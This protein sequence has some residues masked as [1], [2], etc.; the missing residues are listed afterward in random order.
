[1]RKSKQKLSNVAGEQVSTFSV[2]VLL[3]PSMLAQK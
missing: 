2:C 3:G 1:M